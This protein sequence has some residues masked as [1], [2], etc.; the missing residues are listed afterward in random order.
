V[1]RAQA[2][3]ILSGAAQL[4]SFPDQVYDVNAGFDFVDLGHGEE[5]SREWLCRIKNDEWSANEL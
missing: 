4:H 3:I 5:E 1:E 2:G